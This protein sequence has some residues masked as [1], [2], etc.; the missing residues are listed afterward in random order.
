MKQHSIQPLFSLALL[1]ALLMV[2][3]LNAAARTGT[4]QPPKPRWDMAKIAR[5]AKATGHLFPRKKGEDLNGTARRLPGALPGTVNLVLV[6][7][8]REQSKLFKKWSPTITTLMRGYR[9]LDYVWMPVFG[10]RNRVLRYFITNGMK[11]RITSKWARRRTLL[12][13]HDQSLFV[14]GLGLKGNGQMVLCVTDS[15]GRVIATI[16][17]AATPG[18]IAKLKAI[19]KGITK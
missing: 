17:G 14:K 9:N 7:F 19:L 2:F 18:K 16:L 4:K 3:A 1:T 13:F 15:K 8:K 6:G 10:D 12:M 11:K 5:M